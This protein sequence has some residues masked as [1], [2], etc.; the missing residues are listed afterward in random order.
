VVGDC[1]PVDGGTVYAEHGDLKDGT[2]VKEELSLT[3]GET[4]AQTRRSAS[5]S[6]AVKPR[7]RRAVWLT[8]RLLM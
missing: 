7:V 8:S 4:R 6:V 5:K 3:G 2:L 1:I